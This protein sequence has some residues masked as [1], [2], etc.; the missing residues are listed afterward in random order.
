MQKFPD[1]WD[2]KTKINFLQRKVILNC[3][4]YYM[5]DKSP[6]SD[7]Y[8]D[9]MCKQLVGLHK[10]YGDISDT[11]YGYVM[12]DFDGSTGYDLYYRLNEE[13]RAYLYNIAEH[14]LIYK[15]TGDGLCP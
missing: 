1:G 15:N 2:L 11:K 4:A 14:A 5:F 6:L 12:R 8:Y 7:Y 10:E 13:D 9:T 3:I